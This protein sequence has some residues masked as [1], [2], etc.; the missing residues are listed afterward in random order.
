MGATAFVM[1]EMLGMPYQKVV[2]AAIIPA[3]LY[4]ATIFFQVDMEAGKAGLKGLRR[5]Q[6]P[7]IKSVLGKIHFFIILIQVKLIPYLKLLTDG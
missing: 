5:E 3:F 7:K 1:A 4:Y 2:I 6:L